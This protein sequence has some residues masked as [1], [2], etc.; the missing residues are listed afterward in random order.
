MKTVT[1]RLKYQKVFLIFYLLHFTVFVTVAL[2][3]HFFT[4]SPQLHEKLLVV[5]IQVFLESEDDV[6]QI[7]VSPVLSYFLYS[8]LGPTTLLK[9]GLQHRYFP[10]NFAK[11]LRT[12][13]FI[14]HLRWL[15]LFF[16]SRFSSFHVNENVYFLFHPLKKLGTCKCED[17]LES[18]CQKQLVR[19]QFHITR[20]CYF[21]TI[22]LNA[23]FVNGDRF[24]SS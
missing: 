16:I 18:A 17:I 2:K 10:V 13:I 4:N 6:I 22:G 14:E 1:S 20:T 24:D 5:S 19:H 9:K 7:K 15:L 11:F 3:V 12:P 8:G 21:L 23:Q